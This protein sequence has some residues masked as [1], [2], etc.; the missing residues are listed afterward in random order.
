MTCSRCLPPSDERET[1]RRETG[2]A[3]REGEARHMWEDKDGGEEVES[4]RVK[5]KKDGERLKGQGA[6]IRM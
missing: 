2:S 4:G 6:V 5:K 3:K 1:D